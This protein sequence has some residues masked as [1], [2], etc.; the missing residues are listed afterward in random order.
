MSPQLDLNDF[1]FEELF[2]PEGLNRLDARFL[3]RLGVQAPDL[4]RWLEGY[5]RGAPEHGAEPGAEVS[6]RLIELAAWVEHELVE[7]FGVRMESDALSGETLEEMDFGRFRSELVGKRARRFRG[8]IEDG[9]ALDSKIRRAAGLM[10][11]QSG[12]ADAERAICRYGLSLLDDDADP[13]LL[14]DLVRWC[15]LGLREPESISVEGWTVFKLPNKTDYA[16]LVSMQ[17]VVGDELCRA[18]TDPGGFRQRDGFAL[19]DRRMS[20]REAMG[21][22]DYCIYCHDHDGDFCSRGFPEKKT[23]PELGLKTNP[24]GE[25]LTGCPLGERVSEMHL[26]KSRG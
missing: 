5:R 10:A 12:G 7:L 20:R 17:P 11:T 18:Q 14:E 4:A 3:A 22:V 2:T 23:K 16:R 1:R 26:L 19:T 25:V 13:A 15:A 6:E 21:E 8:D 24:L 9:A